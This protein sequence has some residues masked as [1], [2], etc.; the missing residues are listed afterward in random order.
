MARMRRI[1]V[2]LACIAALCFA[3]ALA[4]QGTRPGFWY[5]LGIGEGWARVSCSICRADHQPGLSAHLGLGGGMSRTVLIAGEVA[6]WRR[7]VNGVRQTLASVGAAA[8]WYP[9]R[10]GGGPFYLKGGLRYLTHHAEDGTDAITS[11]GL[12]PELGAGYELPVSR[13]MVLA[14]Y[15][16]VAYGSWFGGVKFNGAQAVDQATVTLVQVG[17]S[18]TGRP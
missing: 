18:L 4:A 16:T 6:A 12:G 5:S 1:G 17:V 9:G 14:P 11:T 15:F 3:R 10:R 8:Y 2:L 7:N 13:T